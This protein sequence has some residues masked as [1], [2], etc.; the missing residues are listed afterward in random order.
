MNF[1]QFAEEKLSKFS[2]IFSKF[3]INCLFSPKAQKINAWF[4]NFREKY[5]L[6]MHF[7]NF[8]NKNFQKIFQKIFIFVQT[9]KKLRHDL[10]NSFEKYAKIIHFLSIFW[11]KFFKDFLTISQK[12]VFS[13]KREKINAWFFKIL[14]KNAKLMHFSQFSEEV[15]SKF[16]QQISIPIG[17][18][19]KH[20][21]IF[22]KFF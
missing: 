10:L 7:C 1:L 3:Q 16:S 5:T 18:K 12:F 20:A 6:I 21:E 8:L 4:V 13:S 2:Q 14:L 19:P 17:F 11:W 15:F 22:L 9:R